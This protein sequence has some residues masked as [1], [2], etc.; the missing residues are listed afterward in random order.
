MTATI[1]AVVLLAGLA[2][3]ARWL[4]RSGRRVSGGVLGLAAVLSALVAVRDLPGPLIDALVVAVL[5]VIAAVT[6]W[7]L[8]GP[9][10]VA[11]RAGRDGGES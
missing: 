7:P 10:R 8:L 9:R 3:A 1:V 5:L 11:D 2:L 6:A 4:W